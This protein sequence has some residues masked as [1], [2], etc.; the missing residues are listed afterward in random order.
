MNDEDADLVIDILFSADG[1][2]PYCVASLLRKFI[3]HYPRY[4]QQIHDK[5]IDKYKGDK[6]YDIDEIWNDASC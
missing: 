3:D 5:F 6:W 4:E 1:G 2:C